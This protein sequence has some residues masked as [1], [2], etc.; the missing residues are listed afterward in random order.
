MMM[1]YAA[2]IKINQPTNFVFTLNANPLP[3]SNGFDYEKPTTP[4][5]ANQNTL[6]S[7][8]I[9]LFDDSEIDNEL[10]FYN[11]H[12]QICDKKVLMNVTIPVLVTE[13][14]KP[15]SSVTMQNVRPLFYPQP[16]EEAES[17]QRALKCV[18]RRLSP[19]NALIFGLISA[20]KIS[21]AAICSL[22]FRLSISDW[23]LRQTCLMSG[24]RSSAAKIGNFAPWRF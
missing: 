13:Y 10:H 9:T 7:Q 19:P 1:N 4:F 11:G 17:L 15:N 3:Q 2:A 5:T 20:R 22:V 8:S 12:P 14:K 24:L 23:R 21:I 6:Y 18:F 16:A